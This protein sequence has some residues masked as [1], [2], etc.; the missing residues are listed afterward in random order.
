MNSE[1]WLVR[2]YMSRVMVE[3]PHAARLAAQ[4]LGIEPCERCDYFKPHCRCH[5]EGKGYE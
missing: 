3:A 2:Y 4:L 5:E 1:E